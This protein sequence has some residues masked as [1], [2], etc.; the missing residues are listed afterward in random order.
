MECVVSELEGRLLKDSDTFCYFML[1]AFEAS[2][3]IRFALLL[4]LWP[5]IRILDKVGKGDMGLK[6]M[7][8]AAVA[9]VGESDIEWV[10]RA[11]LPKF[12][13]DDLD[14]EVWKVLSSKKEKRV[15]V[16]KMPRVMV[17][18][19]VKE[20]LRADEVVGVELCV[21]RFGL[22]TGLVRGG[23]IHNVSSSDSKC[24]QE[25]CHN[26]HQLLRPLPVIF[27]DGRLVKR[28][29]PSTALLILLWTPLGIC[30]AII[31][32]IVGSLLPFWATP[33]VSRLFGGKVVVK[34]R[35]P[36]PASPGNSG[37]L[38]VCT[39]RTLMDPVV[40]SAV[41]RRQIPAVTYSISRL[42]EMLSPIPTVRLTR[43]RHVDAEKI[44]EELSK[45]D[46]VVCP[47]G[48]TCREPFL[49]RFSALFAELTD[50]IVPVAMNYRVGFF[51]ATTARGWKGLDPIFF[52][53]NP[54][55]VYEVTFLNQLPV[56]A[57]C[58]S[59]KSP[60]DVANYVQRILAATL[61]FECTNFTRRDKY[62]VLAG[63]DGSV[64]S[65]T[66]FVH[67]IKKV[68]TTFKPFLQ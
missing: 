7:I 45:G 46:L 68:I 11:V 51:H 61:G 29:T 10:A 4:L 33:Y 39:H 22:A 15:V 34:G 47:E 65:C 43:I 64:S 13:M 52:F 67:R 57:T 9:G 19:F 26:E 44:K 30:L 42:S 3:L 62:R 27:H 63:N 8:F 50:R 60:H 24:M 49:L 2:G 36:P 6:V 14:M 59:G 25:K 12:L 38:F 16:T 53:M 32:I 28:P 20:H 35:P 17:E 31:R 21:N 56:E 41:L 37:V 23:S 48:T 54:R 58:S 18:R 1:V 40:L 55:P 5:V 66:S